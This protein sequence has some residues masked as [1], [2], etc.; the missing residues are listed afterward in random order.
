MKQLTNKRPNCWIVF[1][2]DY[3]IPN[4]DHWKKQLLKNLKKVE[5][6]PVQHQHKR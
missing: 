6:T 5:L 3:G 2:M 1:H 4:K